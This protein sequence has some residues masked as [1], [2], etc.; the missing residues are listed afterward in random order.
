MKA[1]DVI[2]AG[3]VNDVMAVPFKK[4]FYRHRAYCSCDGSLKVIDVSEEH[5]S[6]SPTLSSYVLAGIVT[7]AN[8]EQSLNE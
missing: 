8:E 1:N 2:D 6:N 5:P 7:S 3:S 4:L